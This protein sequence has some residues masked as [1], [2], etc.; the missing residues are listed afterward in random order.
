M[1]FVISVVWQVILIVGNWAF[2]LIVRCQNCYRVLALFWHNNILAKPRTKVTTVS[3]FS[4]QNRDLQIR[5]RLRVRVRV[6]LL[7]ARGLG[8]SCR[9]HCCCRRQLATKIFQS[10]LRVRSY[11]TLSVAVM[12]SRQ[13]AQDA[14]KSPKHC[15]ITCTEHFTVYPRL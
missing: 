3:R 11:N 9:G 10:F 5:L 12:F 4:S 8:I 2:L 6:R 7:S 14:T 1:H 13:T 15:E